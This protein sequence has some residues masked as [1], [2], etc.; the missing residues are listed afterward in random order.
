MKTGKRVLSFLLSAIMVLSVF[1]GVGD[2]SSLFD[3]E[4]SAADITLGG[5]TQKRVV[6]NYENVYAGY[7]AKYFG[8]S[9]TNWPTNFVIPGLSSSDDYTPQGMTYWE[10]KEWILISAYDASGSGKNSVIYALDAVTTEFVAL[11]RVFDADGSVNTSHGG[12]IAASKYNFYYADSGSKISYVP[13]SEMNVAKGTV[14][15]IRLQGSINCAGE[16]NN[17][18]TS[19]CCYDEGV[20][21]TGNFYLKNDDYDYNQPANAN[22]NS[23]LLG[24]KLAGNSSAE[25]WY[26]LSQ[27]YNHVVIAVPSGSAEIS[28]SKM[29]YTATNHNGSNAEIRGSIKYGGTPVGEFTQ[30]FAQMALKEGAKYKFEFIVNSY[31]NDT[32]F[33]MFA[34]NGK[35]MDV[36]LAKDL[37]IT[38]IGD[39]RFH[40]ELVFT[41]GLK[42]EGTDSSWPTTQSTDGSFTGT[43]TLRFDQ[44]AISADRD[45][46]ITD[47]S[48][49][50][51]APA[52]GFTPD[53]QYEGIGCEGNP[54]YAIAIDNTFDKIQYAMVDKGKIYMSRSWSRNMTGSTHVRALAIG[55]IDI[56]APGTVSLS[57]NGRTRN[58]H[59][60]ES[61]NVTQFGLDKNTGASNKDILA[62]GEAL[63]V[64][65]DYLYMF[66]E[67]AAWN[68]NGKDS[69]SKCAEPVDVIWKI[70]QHAILGEKRP[71]EEVSSIYYKK[72]TDLSQIQGSDTEYLL[73][74]ESAEKDPVSQKN[75]LYAIDSFGGY[76]GAKLPKQNNFVNTGDSM[77]IV[78]YPITSYSTDTIIDDNYNEYDVIYLNE[79]D[80]NQKS[81]RWNLT[82]DSASGSMIVKN[83]DFYFATNSNLTF[84]ERAFIMSS[85]DTSKI[86]IIPSDKAGSFYLFTTNTRNSDNSAQ[87]SY[88]WCNDGTINSGLDVF[89]QYYLNHSITNYV[90]VYNGA[91]EVKG[92]FHT[93][94]LGIFPGQGSNIMG[95]I[96]AY[97]Y[98][99]FSIYMKVP[100][101]YAGTLETDVYTGLETVLE[102]DGTYTLNLETYATAAVQYM[103]VA[104][105]PTDF[106]FVV[107]TEGTT[108]DGQGYRTESNWSPLKMN[109]AC[110]DKSDSFF[111]EGSN[112][113][114]AHSGNFYFKF[115][116]GE[117]GQIH[118]A[119]NKRDSSYTRDIWLWAEHPITKRCY[120]LSKFGFMTHGNF[121][122]GAD[123]AQDTSYRITDEAF[124][125]NQQNL[126]WANEA[127]VMADVNA[128]RY[129]TD[130]HS[131]RNSTSKRADYE[132]MEYTHNQDGIYV[133]AS[134]YT[135]DAPTRLEAT[136]Q[137]VEKMSYCIAE[138]NT[139]HRISLVTFNNSTNATS[140]MV[141][142]SGSVTTSTS[143]AGTDWSKIYFNNSQ[144]GIFRNQ[145]N[146]LTSSG[147][148]AQ[149]SVGLSRA[150]NTFALCGQD[151]TAA[152][153]RAACVF[154]ITTGQDITTDKINNAIQ[155]AKDCKEYGAFVYTIKVGSVDENSNNVKNFFDYSS[156]NYINA[157]SLTASGERN[158]HTDINYYAKADVSFANSLIKSTI[159]NSTK[160]YL[161]V[162]NNT[163]IRENISNVFDMSNYKISYKEI[164]AAYDGL[165]R[166]Y[167]ND[168]KAT[169]SS[170]ITANFTNNNYTVTV[171]GFNFSENYVSTSHEGKKFVVSIS[172]LTLKPDADLENVNAT[173][174]KTTGL[175]LNNDFLARNDARKRYPMNIIN[176][177]EY[178]YV[179]DFGTQMLDK[180]VNGTLV[181]VDTTPG[182]QST[183]KTELNSA[184]SDAIISFA[185]GNQDLV[186]ALQPDAS[187][188]EARSKG[189]VLIQRDDGTYDWFRI[190]V[191]PASN[192]L[193]EEGSA[194]VKTE[195]AGVNWQTNG[196]PSGV[197]QSLTS[198]NDVY[199]YDEVYN[200]NIGKF[201]NGS[202]LMTS[203]SDTDNRSKTLSF[204]YTGT[205]VDIVSACG[206]ETGIQVVTIR[207]SEG[208][209]EKI[210]IIDTYYTDT[211][212]LTNG[213]LHQVPVI[214]HENADYGTYTVEITAAY[215]ASMVNA[216]PMTMS[217]YS[218]E[219]I[220]FYSPDTSWMVAE[221]VLENIGMEELLGE[222]IEVL[223]ADA[224]SVFNGGTGAGGSAVSTFALGSSNDTTSRPLDSLQ[225][226]FDGFRVY[227]PMGSMSGDYVESE[228]GSSY[229]NVMNSLAT[230][231]DIV[232]G[233]GNNLV[234]YV[235]GN[236]NETIDFSDYGT[237]GSKVPMNEIYLSN[238]NSAIAFNVTEGFQK[239]MISLRAVGKATTVKIG[240]A[241]IPVSSSTEMYYDI[242]NYVENGLV[243]IQNIGDG[244]LAV[245]N[246][247]V[248]DGGIA[249]MMMS[250]LPRMRMMMAAPSEEVIP[251]E[252]STEE[253][254]PVDPDSMPDV[255]EVYP[256]DNMGKEE[257]IPAETP[258]VNGPES[259]DTTTSFVDS[260][261]KIF[262]SIKAFFEKILSFIN[263]LFA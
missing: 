204:S 256:D 179:L 35:H 88:I 49:S 251:N 230:G 129:R 141:S 202:S 11:F 161:K 236:T 138:D 197:S 225:N 217:L 58:C 83:K 30:N 50:E 123:W 36:K 147:N 139:N 152:G 124:I 93:D 212:Y 25:E 20:L 94:A 248:V 188:E 203:V 66:A 42:S 196:T 119:F 102:A 56:N 132:V 145:V 169:N 136:K 171:N 250:A 47:I 226:Y 1:A 126:G 17:A 71:A 91:T 99:Y 128:D 27:N 96:P 232:S 247:K 15:D 62:M 3:I 189:Y 90:P 61:R 193:Y 162:D 146:A 195:T 103:D 185:N 174:D 81:I 213:L 110:G 255:P 113:N 29:T 87:P 260:I 156:S 85:S 231:G 206:P 142:S 205:A 79:T 69:S 187:G 92:T 181:S 60:V 258:E 73:V 252:P 18:Y 19:Y 45:F 149:P 244:L 259:S 74:Y 104:Q 63:C 14:K 237:P 166:L 144:F 34:P 159:K 131:S 254:T 77:G 109:Q 111:S 220:N 46:V 198:K 37:K 154:L 106:I 160:A 118:V 263:S 218:D 28:G 2:L 262:D 208:K 158:K 183:Y 33:Y 245:G 148:V 10:E 249:P 242:T 57:V 173:D 115:P 257:D 246:I 120:R 44:D 215:L 26:Y 184:D 261:A 180:D 95:S 137:F 43:Y 121:A 53:S 221:A 151:Y 201:S 16:M 207:N 238:K 228:R 192:V 224:N 89:T 97:S 223:F 54:T 12:G 6:S 48:V 130:Y 114:T 240:S 239:T 133:K 229:Y 176:V 157:E 241:Q 23:M 7:R 39:G 155:M 211:D 5:I 163:I 40:Y 100:D 177:P 200:N 233:T 153:D 22:Y 164:P 70:D 219:V 127:A 51:Y 243:T 167:F 143:V 170:N 41:A 101:P 13:L 234:A 31:N 98:G 253:L 150:A 140:Y 107:D 214:H 8:D 112:Y 38:P 190:N 24:Y 68:Y 182:K 76:N 125:A 108:Y 216:R 80:D 210:Y 165:D 235:E 65:N 105:R 222:D 55:D 134:Y 116:D 64:M 122:G 59:L 178:T 117:F 191:V 175:Y 52:E 194:T 67:S 4:A 21:W 84:N 209:V 199:G 72:V 9:N 78:G 86:G 186:Y 32:D 168:D 82:Y 135:T 227:N 75:I 172:G